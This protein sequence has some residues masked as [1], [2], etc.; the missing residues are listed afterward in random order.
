MSWSVQ[1][2]TKALPAVWRLSCG[3]CHRQYPLVPD[4]P[5]RPQAHDV[6]ARHDCKGPDV[7]PR[8][9]AVQALA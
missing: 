1:V 4:Q 3:D 7:K 9:E 2:N 5:L 8:R 6:F